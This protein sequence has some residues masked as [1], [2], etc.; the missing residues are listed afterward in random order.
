MNKK[1]I[2]LWQ[3][4]PL[5]DRPSG[6]NLLV[7]HHGFPGQYTHLIK[8][9]CREGGHRIVGLGL[10]QKPTGI[11]AEVRY[12]PYQL[13]RGNTKGIHGL[14]RETETKVIRAQP[15]AEQA[16]RLRQAGFMPDLI[17]AHPGWGESLFLKDIW[18]NVPMLTYQEFFYN[19]SGS[20]VDFDPE[21][22]QDHSWEYAAT[23]RMK[24][25][26]VLM[27]L[28]ASDWCLTP[29]QFQY[30]SYPEHWRARISI[31]HDGIDTEQAVPLTDP[32]PLTLPGGITLQPGTPLVTFVNRTLEPY[33]GCHTF[34]RAIPQLQQLMPEA[35]V[36][37]VGRTEGV[38]YGS[39]CPTGEW[40]DRFL[41]EIEGHYDAS[42]IHFVGHLPYASYLHL[43]QLSRCHVYLTYPFVLSWSLLEAMSAGCAVV[44][45]A[46]APVQEVVQDG[47]NGLLVDFFRPNDLATAMAELLAHPERGQL[48][49]REARRTVVERYSLARCL[50]RQRA[51]L[52]LVSSR[53]LNAGGL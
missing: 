3:P 13:R 26:N 40:K 51:L 17:C 44:G 42:K 47:V 22:K 27:S 43:L 19:S 37:I 2:H 31:I 39:A 36:V 53:T 9:L 29:T 28:E 15:C 48:L 12:V 11:P 24:S 20:D 14:V 52:E 38:S 23:I 5:A 21:F 7:V 6:M 30:N 1:Q 10:R 35:R 45:S 33:R 16:L 4:L 41:S 50:P 25:A 32:A 8:L 49:G 18:P 46:T 34:L